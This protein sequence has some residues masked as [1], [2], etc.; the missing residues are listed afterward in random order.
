MLFARIFDFSFSL[1]SVG[2]QDNEI[3]GVKDNKIP[4]LRIL[5]FVWTL[6]VMIMY[7]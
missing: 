1:E 5:R 7:S 3:P 2:D 6:T 4:I